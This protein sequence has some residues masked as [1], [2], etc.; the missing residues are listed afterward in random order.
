MVSLAGGLFGVALIAASLAQRRRHADVP[1]AGLVPMRALAA[2]SVALCAGAGRFVVLFGRSEPGSALSSPVTALSLA[3]LA[4]A[5]FATLVAE[6]ALAGTSS[7]APPAGG[8]ASWYFRRGRRHRRRRTI[9]PG[10]LGDH[11]RVAPGGREICA[12]A[13][14][15]EKLARV[16]AETKAGWRPL[17]VG[18]GVN[19]SR[20]LKAG[21]IGVC[22]G[23]QGDRC[24]AGVR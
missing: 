5:G 1:P 8:R 10:R 11:R 9:E 4:A 15:E 7:E 23:L 22:M 13:L 20:A 21:A 14:P 19:D 12:E 16:V 3:G 17:V 2:V 6:R 18:D 24:R